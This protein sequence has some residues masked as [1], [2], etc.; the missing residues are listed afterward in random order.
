MKKIFILILFLLVSSPLF[1]RVA[2]DDER[3]FTR[4]EIT[5][6]EKHRIAGDDNY[7]LYET[8][9][10]V[11][12]LDG[13]LKGQTKVATFRGEH[14]LPKDMFYKEG[15]VVFIGISKTGLENTPEY[16]SLYDV[17][18]TTMIIILTTLLIVSVI[19]I[20][21]TK[22]LFSLLALIVTI[23]LLFF[24]LIP[25]TLKGYPPLPLAIV[26]AIISTVLTLPVIAGFKK[27]TFAAILG[28]SAGIIIASILAYIV[29]NIMHLSGF[30]T[31]EMLTVFYV[32]DVSIDVRGLAL[33]SIIIAAL[34]AVMDVCI[35]IA[36]ATAEI[37]SANPDLSHREAF[38][39][40]LNIGTDILGSMVNTL[41][42]AYVGSSLSLILLISMR[43]QPGMPVW[44]IFNYNPILSEI[45]KSIIGSIGMFICIPIT[46]FISVHL[47]GRKDSAR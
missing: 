16:I 19:L 47:Y 4:A 27:K 23:L 14:D 26:I 39:S 21:K 35:S 43:I 33:A 45:V 29:G 2:Y 32:A 42:L 18:N 15:D 13:E 1:A 37:Y 7:P 17:D 8:K 25:L 34:G 12:I 11:T 44:M 20:G 36:S 6:I 9:I 10:H 3:I 30:V 5:K 28:A 38:A 31:N 24:V 22:G 41:I 40:V 46:A